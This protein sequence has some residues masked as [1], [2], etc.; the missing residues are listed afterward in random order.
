[1]TELFNWIILC[2]NVVNTVVM[3][4]QPCYTAGQQYEAAYQKKIKG[5]GNTTY[6]DRGGGSHA[7]NVQRTW[8][9]GHCQSTTRT[10]TY[11]V[12][13]LSGHTPRHRRTLRCARSCFH[14]WKVFWHAKLRDV[15][16]G[17]NEFHQTPEKHYLT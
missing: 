8:S 12:G 17:G 7:W 13:N 10:S 16:G 15:G 3:T 14:R 9:L 4:Y 6:T 5:E 2:I 11:V 1:M